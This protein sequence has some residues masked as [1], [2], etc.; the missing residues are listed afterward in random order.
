MSS[1]GALDGGVSSQSQT[2]KVSPQTTPSTSPSLGPTSGVDRPKKMVIPPGH[3]LHPKTKMMLAKKQMMMKAKGLMG[4]GSD[5]ATSQQQPPAAPS[6]EGPQSVQVAEEVSVAAASITTTAADTTTTAPA[7]EASAIQPPSP[8]G[9]LSTTTGSAC[10]P[11]APRPSTP[12]DGRT[13]AQ[14]RY[15]HRVLDFFQRYDPLRMPTEERVQRIVSDDGPPEHI[16]FYI[17]RKKY[18]LSLQQAGGSSGGAWGSE[19]KA[20]HQVDTTAEGIEGSTRKQHTLS[21][22]ADHDVGSPYRANPN[23]HDE[24]Y[25]HSP[26]H[27]KPIRSTHHSPKAAPPDAEH[28]P[29]AQ[30]DEEEG[31]TSLQSPTSSSAPVLD[32]RSLLPLDTWLP[33]WDDAVEGV[34][35]VNDFVPVSWNS[36]TN[37]SANH[38]GG[39]SARFKV[40]D[41]RTPG[42]NLAQRF[43][44][45]GTHF[46]VHH[47]L[48]KARADPEVLMVADRLHP[49]YWAQVRE[50]GDGGSSSSSTSSN[51]DGLHNNDDQDNNAK[52]DD[53]AALPNV[54]MPPAVDRSGDTGGVGGES[55]LVDAFAPLSQS[56]KPKSYTKASQRAERKLLLRA[57]KRMARQTELD[58]FGTSSDGAVAAAC[59]LHEDRATSRRDRGS[60]LSSESETPGSPEFMNTPHD[61]NTTTSGGHFNVDDVSH[62]DDEGSSAFI[63]SLSSP[64]SLNAAPEDLLL[65][66]D[67][68]ASFRSSS[69]AKRSV[70]SPMDFE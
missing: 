13:A 67:M 60:R 30:E 32:P 31:N 16:F 50:H 47:G 59:Y 5:A 66:D 3:P 23:M 1:S 29:F 34:L 19:E 36:A 20:S 9:E 43:L 40:A 21:V 10:S 7:L 8:N 25:N 58:L 33:E 12:L 41:G 38:Q 14:R 65:L 53:D 27:P 11:V 46:I 17:L 49:Y 54:P 48:M 70:P 24:H 55:A 35:P 51:A 63:S 62:D 2:P 61:N 42:V 57:V 4:T 56:S 6:A 22:E 15:T 44:N 52:T 26:N 68:D 18:G 64:P 69:T 28:G 37:G 45:N 39:P